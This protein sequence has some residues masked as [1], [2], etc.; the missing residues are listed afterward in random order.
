M[1][2]DGSSLQT[3]VECWEGLM[4]LY[5]GPRGASRLSDDP[6]ALTPPSPLATAPFPCS[7]LSVTWA[8]LAVSLPSTHLSFPLLRVNRVKCHFLKLT[9]GR[10]ILFAWGSDSTIEIQIQI[11]PRGFFHGLL[12]TLWRVLELWICDLWVLYRPRHKS[13][14]RKFFFWGTWCISL[15]ITCQLQFCPL[16]F[17]LWRKHDSS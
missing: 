17:S 6:C 8:T 2:C 12:K 9:L 16:C 10:Y 13:W 14:Y 4:F 11:H 15:Q 5:V 7:G 3:S 1:W